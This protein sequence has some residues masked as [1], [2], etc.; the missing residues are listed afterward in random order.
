MPARPFG[1][2][3]FF[4]GSNQE[5]WYAKKM[6][7]AGGVQS[8]DTQ[9]NQRSNE[10]L[11]TETPVQP[12]QEQGT[13]VS[14]D[15]QDQM[16][17]PSEIA[18]PQEA[19]SES[20]HDGAK[21]VTDFL[22][23]LPDA[24]GQ[25]ADG[26]LKTDRFVQQVVDPE[27]G[28]WSKDDLAKALFGA[29]RG[30]LVTN[31]IRFFDHPESS[32]VGKIAKSGEH[33]DEIFRALQLS[34]PTVSIETK[35]E[36]LDRWWS[37]GRFEFIADNFD[38]FEIAQIHPRPAEYQDDK[39][40]QENIIDRLLIRGQ[41]ETILDNRE[42][43]TEI[44]LSDNALAEKLIAHGSAYA[45]LKSLPRFRHLSKSVAEDILKD[46]SVAS[47]RFERLRTLGVSSSVRGEVWEQ[48][49]NY[50][51]K[52]LDQDFTKEDLG[53]LIITNTNADTST[54]VHLLGLTYTERLAVT[55]IKR[56][57]D[58]SNYD[59]L[60][61]FIENRYLFDVSWNDDELANKLLSNDVDPFNV[62]YR[63]KYLLP[64]TFH[65]IIEYR[66]RYSGYGRTALENSLDMLNNLDKF[67]ALSYEDLSLLTDLHPDEVLRQAERSPGC[68]E[69]E[70][71][72]ELGVLKENYLL[73]GEDRISYSERVKMNQTS[74]RPDELAKL[75]AMKS[76]LSETNRLTGKKDEIKHYQEAVIKR[77][78][79]RQAVETFLLEQGFTDNQLL[80]FAYRIG[81][82][83]HD[84]FVAAEDIGRMFK[85]SGLTPDRFSGQILDQVA[86]DDVTYESGC[87]NNELNRIANR[88]IRSLV[89]VR[90]SLNTTESAPYLARQ[91]EMIRQL[92]EQMLSEFKSNE[93]IFKSWRTL[94]SYSEKTKIIL[95]DRERL[96]TIARLQGEGKE[97]L[98]KWYGIISASN[99]VS[100]EAL[101]EFISDPQDFFERDASHTPESLH[102]SKKPSN[103]VEIPNLDL[104]PGELRDALVE[105]K[106]DHLASLPAYEM[107]YK[108]RS[109]DTKEALSALLGSRANNIP[110]AANNA[111]ELFHSLRQA[112]TQ[113]G[114]SPKDYLAGAAV[115]PEADRLIR[116][117]V[118]QVIA[119]GGYNKQIFNPHAKSYI[120]SIYAKSSPFGVLA[121][122]DT[123]CCMPFGDGKNNVYMFNPACS[124]FTIQE[125][126]EDGTRRTIIQSVMSLNAELNMQKTVDKLID[127]NPDNMSDILPEDAYKNSRRLVVADNAE[128][129]PNF[130]T[131]TNAHRISELVYGDFFARYLAELSQVRDV[132]NDEVQ[133]G[134]NYSKTL[135]HLPRVPNKSVP[136]APVSYSDNIEST[137]LSLKPEISTNGQIESATLLAKGDFSEKQINPGVSPLTFEDTLPTAYLEGKVYGGT[138]LFSGLHNMENGLIAKDINNSAKNRP[139]MSFKYLGTDNTLEAYILAYQG[140]WG[141]GRDRL[142]RSDWD[143]EG[144]MRVGEADYKGKSEEPCI[145]IS[146][147]AS[148]GEKPIA[149]GKILNQFVNTYKE[150]YIDRGNALPIYCQAR[151]GSSYEIITKQLPRFAE[152][153]GVKLTLEEVSQEETDGGIMHTVVI[154]PTV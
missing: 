51:E 3:G 46:R 131:Q 66:N 43:F 4:V 37:N 145:Y 110:G 2:A 115:N 90:E 49:V 85:Q 127:E 105:G 128:V 52:F 27:T 136:V 133:I 141:A 44:D 153:L 95:E 151:E 91:N 34:D 83:R 65:S 31:N 60:N 29:G 100:T 126:M 74:L 61:F 13:E 147:Y 33:Q 80:R 87:A 6:N 149:A 54:L 118:D 97:N 99:N 150:Q 56:S 77:L 103:Y 71:F 35:N 109:H 130:A 92:A 21:E 67:I 16:I 81:L 112:L 72:K 75:E 143:D 63:F 7:E 45:L 20:K 23:S 138:D 19:P 36:I 129:A 116:E 107:E 73:L 117:K 148:R 104:S 101:A 123:A 122:N 47:T 24:Y 88:G 8:N 134:P 48:I 142:E 93:D 30:Y 18:G 135:T 64:S 25:F 98:A 76:E 152:K 68:I 39:S 1:T 139:E 140:I 89:E 120:A 119:D 9:E 10:E 57:G 69:E 125:P 94:R 79:N 32:F 102:D 14:P 22:L 137:S 154:R 40:L 62:H 12:E 38:K 11:L 146:D 113:C 26:I 5:N 86:K 82:S 70:A 114:I 58:H 132:K 96:V 15:T 17:R 106:M 84:A 28:N 55:L 41:A 121:G 42:K 111:N 144:Y 108:V 53:E 124:Q 50:K 59:R 78:P